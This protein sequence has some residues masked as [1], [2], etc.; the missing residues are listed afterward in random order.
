[1]VEIVAAARSVLVIGGKRSH[2]DCRNRATDLLLDGEGR[3]RHRIER[4]EPDVGRQVGLVLVQVRNRQVGN[5]PAFDP[6]DHHTLTR[7]DAL[8]AIADHP[9]RERVRGVDL[10]DLRQGCHDHAA[11]VAAGRGRGQMHA[12]ARRNA[13]E[14]E[15]AGLVDLQRQEIAQI[16]RIVIIGIGVSGDVMLQRLSGHRDELQIDGTI[17]LHALD[18]QDGKDKITAGIDAK[19]DI[20]LQAGSGNH[21]VVIAEQSDGFVVCCRPAAG[22]TTVSEIA[23]PAVCSRVVANQ[24]HRGAIAIVISRKGNSRDRRAVRR[25]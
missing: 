14:V 9:V 19:G 23:Q 1:M 3:T 12:L 24:R 21:P 15:A 16:D 11:A 20:P 7:I 22:R 10:H 18:H 25:N 8:A 17:G 13:Q 2:R 6:G 5:K 4:S